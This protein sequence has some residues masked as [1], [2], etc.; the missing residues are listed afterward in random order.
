MKTI[1]SLILSLAFFQTLHAQS[2]TN[3][4]TRWTLEVI[5]G[6][7][8]NSQQLNLR[9]DYG[10][11]REALL[12]DGLNF[13]Y[14]S[15]LASQATNT[16]ASFHQWLRANYLSH[17]KNYAD[18]KQDADNRETLRKLTILL[19]AESDLLSNADL[20]NLATIA[21]KAP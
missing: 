21:A 13:A 4:I 17:V 7:I 20:N 8:T 3:I 16:P 1:L 6:G 14:S 18:Q 15:Y 9:W 11:K 10:T 2:T 19:T 5:T 12:I